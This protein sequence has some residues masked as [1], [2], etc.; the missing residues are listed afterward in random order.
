[1][2]SVILPPASPT[3]RM[4]KF[5]QGEKVI[6]N[7]DDNTEIWYSIVMLRVPCIVVSDIPRVSQVGNNKR[8][9][10]YSHDNE[11]DQGIG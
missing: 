4:V 2:A 11:R 9:V 3:L 8:D 7:S 1:M 10:I 6:Y 5:L